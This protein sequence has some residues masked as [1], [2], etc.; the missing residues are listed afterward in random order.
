MFMRSFISKFA[1]GGLFWSGKGSEAV[2]AKNNKRKTQEM[3]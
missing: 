3:S 2:L 1:V